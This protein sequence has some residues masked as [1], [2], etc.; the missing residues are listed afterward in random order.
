MPTDLQVLHW[1]PAAGRERLRARA[2]LLA[3]IREFFR[4][5]G[6]LEVETPMLSAAGNSDPG[7]RQFSLQEAPW[8]LRTS[9]EYA[10]KRLLAAEI[11][12]LYELGRVFR[13]GEQ[14]RHHNPE[15]TMLE[16]YRRG[17]RYQQLMDELAEL[18]RHCLP[19]TA[20]RETRITYREWLQDCSGVDP[21]AD[22]DQ[23]IRARIAQTDFDVPGLDRRGMLDLL[24]THA[25]QPQL[26]DDQLTFVF[27]FPP[28]QA[29]LARIHPGPPAVAERFEL[30]LGKVELANGY[31]E[32][33]DATEQRRRFEQENAQRRSAGAPEVPLDER[34]LA[35]LHAGLP[36]CAGVA[37]GVDRLLMRL[38]GASALQDVLA[39]PANR[40]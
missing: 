2:D 7:I 26:P 21:L 15:F 30:F 6:V 3:A 10:M 12:D 40:A 39:F 17:W 36:D 27:D 25:A 38:C 18:V 8:W 1:M 5:R 4:Q 13:A 29:A 11:G 37:L 20:L 14:G 31:Q 32:L 23:A 9:S 28:E 24:V 33:T 22:S 16:W 19:G 34:L 35:A